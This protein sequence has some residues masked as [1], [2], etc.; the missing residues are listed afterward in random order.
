MTRARPIRHAFA[1]AQIGVTRMLLARPDAAIG[2]GLPRARADLFAS[3]DRT[4]FRDGAGPALPW[5][6]SPEPPSP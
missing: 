2:R 5:S 6:L 4:A 1:T 3:R